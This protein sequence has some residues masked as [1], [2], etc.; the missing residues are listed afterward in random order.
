VDDRSAWPPVAETKQPASMDDIV[1]RF[2]NGLALEDFTPFHRSLEL[3]LSR[4]YWRKRGGQAFTEREVPNDITN[5]GTRAARAA[6]V[7]FAH[8]IE[9][10]ESGGLGGP[11]R[12]LEFGVG[13]GLFA[14]LFLWSFRDLCGREKRDFFARLTYYATDV[15][16]RNLAD[17]QRLGTLEE[18]GEHVRLGQVD[19]TRPDELLPLGAMRAIFHNYLYDALPQSLVLRQDGRWYEL[20][21]QARLEDPWRVPELT[22]MSLPSFIEIL[23]RGDEDSLDALVPLFSYVQAERSFFPVD[24][25]TVPFGAEVQQFADAA[26]QPWVDATVGQDRNVRMWVPWGGM[27]SFQGSI[28]LLEPDGLMLFTDYGSTELSEVTGA[29]VYQR[30]GAGVCV[31]VNFP[32]LDGFMRSQGFQVSVPA[33]DD[34]L[35]LHARL[36]S[37]AAL[38]RTH[39]RFVDAFAAAD[40]EAMDTHLADGRRLSRKDVAKAL[41]H[42]RSAVQMFPCNWKVLAELAHVENAFAENHEGALALIDQAIALNPTCSSDL[43]S[44][45]G[46]ILVL[47][48]QMAEAERSYARGVALNGMHSRCHYNLAWL[49]AEQGRFPEALEACGRAL[50]TDR[51]G[52]ASETIL[53]KQKDILARRREAYDAERERILLRH[54]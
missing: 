19:A 7:L 40:F 29:R 34:D 9:L 1:A 45:R 43:W 49:W 10:A 8:C 16:E 3:R 21:I 6:E 52:A 4:A 44:E 26:L 33:G 46:D 47:L 11:I 30:Y 39:V 24:L 18:F 23:R 28:P 38:P 13:L 53:A 27:T 48:G 15:S 17:I 32:L 2:P 25:T 5:D 36:A 12:V 20:Y 35:P 54:T 50:A 14:R 22:D 37:K 42:Y 51:T 41:E 31:N